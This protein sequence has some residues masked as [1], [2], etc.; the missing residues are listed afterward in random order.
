MNREFNYNH[1]DA[2]SSGGKVLSLVAFTL[3]L[4]EYQQ[5]VHQQWVAVRLI[6]DSIVPGSR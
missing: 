4:K 1:R 6:E 3:R 2:R 5:Q